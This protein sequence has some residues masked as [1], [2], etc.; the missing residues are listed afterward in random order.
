MKGSTSIGPTVETHDPEVEGLFV[1]PAVVGNHLGGRA[2]QLE[3]ECI[4]RP[5][6]LAVRPGI[7]GLSQSFEGVGFWIGWPVRTDGSP[8]REV[9]QG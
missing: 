4:G 3:M 7:D 6:R 9:A 5:E 8:V 2:E 1:H